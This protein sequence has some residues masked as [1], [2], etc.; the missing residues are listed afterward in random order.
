MSTL[1]LGF[2][3]P[4]QIS[5]AQRG[6]IT[7]PNRKSLA[8]LAYLAVESASAHS[9]ES[10]LSL[11]WPESPTSAA[12]NNLRVTWSILRK[13]LKE[14]SS[15]QEPFLQST[16][17][18]LQFN[19][20]S[21]HWLDVTAFENLLACCNTHNHAE[22]QNCDECATRLAQAAELVRGEFLG[23]FS[24]GD[25]PT[26]DEW[27]LI[28]RERLHLQI[29][30][31]LDDLTNYHD[32]AGNFDQATSYA[33][34]LLEL[35][36]L[37]EEAHRQL[38]RLFSKTGRR[39]AALS[40]FET[41]RRW[42]ANELGVAPSVETTLLAERI[43]ALAPGRPIALRHNLPV[44]TSRFFGRKQEI[45]TLKELLSESSEF[46][47]LTGPG[48]VGKT[49]LALQVASGLVD[50]FSDGVWFV[51]LSGIDDPQVVPSEVSKVLKVQEESERAMA[52][53]LSNGLQ[54]KSVLL[55][56]DNCEHLLEACTQLI[57]SLRASAPGLVVLATSRVPLRLDSERVVRLQPFAI[58]EKGQIL[59]AASALQYEA[60]QLFTS[61]TAKVQLNFTLTDAN[62]MIVA[63]ICRHLDGMPLAIELA[64][65][66][67]RSMPVEAIAQRLDQRFRWLNAQSSGLIP[68]QR[69]LLTMI[70][71]SHDLLDA[72]E[73]ELFCRLSV[74][75]GGWTVAAAE[76]ICAE[77]EFCL[78][79]LTQL[80]DQS[81][82][83]F[84]VGPAKNR[85]RM[86][87]TIRQYARQQLRTSGEE[88]EVLACHAQYY[89]DLVVQAAKNTP[90]QPLQDRLNLIEA[91]HDNLRPA[92]NWTVTHDPDLALKLVAKLGLDLKFWELRGHF[93]EGRRW[94]Q[95]ILDAT[96]DSVSKTRANA[97]L[98]A[99]ALSSAINDFD[100]GLC[101][102]T[103][104]QY[105]FRQI[106]DLP[107][108]VEAQ[109][110]TA[111]LTCLQGE[112]TGPLAMA[113]EAFRIADQIN[114]Q[115][116]LAKG[117][118]VMGA[119]IYDLADYD[120]AIQHLLPS[121]AL[122]RKL[123]K[124]Y[125][126]A[127]T[128]NTLAACLMEKGD[129]VSASEI[130]QE[131]A[132]I[133]RN[134]SYQRGVAL[135]LHNLAD[136]AMHLGDFQRARELNV[137]S[138]QI[139]RELGL[140]RGYAF[141][142]ENFAILADR[143]NQTAR[144]IQLFAAAQALRQAMCAPIDP[145]T[146]EA[147]THLLADLRTK[148]GEVHYELEWSKGHSMTTDQAIELALRDF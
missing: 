137:E 60:V 115:P 62:A 70:D 23:G 66:R 59:N 21:D 41:C 140:R 96:A 19:S 128:L 3:G 124:P 42:L 36:P 33:R 6:N 133:N 95:R 107:G 145:V 136:A 57:K 22:V 121:V 17:L 53:S 20:L 119:I 27:A 12:Q 134:L 142:L 2:L 44:A 52:Q 71:W 72:P 127:R 106:G 122:W 13:S 26:F 49:R 67:A 58:P 113:Q 31:V 97:L 148:V 143:K 91:E 85:Y 130:L 5:H 88:S 76:A 14:V 89:V 129:Y 109:L 87:E 37:R 73:R 43:R 39:S 46:V 38:M 65:T 1:K 112:Q 92:F 93:E 63:Q 11:L 118:Y 69:T 131:T 108:E 94:L 55:V 30:K 28:Q 100:Y 105:I 15:E 147:Y 132:E 51:E 144:S 98:A 56:L 81:L 139:R 48:G 116:G 120:H 29:T 77:G 16:R 4:P 45:D 75:A 64:A 32:V 146:Q 86:H 111:D 102:A 110:E 123:G 78:E 83:D 74:F 9:R 40:Q 103:E 114:D 25:C 50:R 82:I 84:G 126:L 99:A 18:E 79:I 117:G 10:L 104:S 135:A 80:V 7:L 141:S 54:D 125:E 8:L 138:L 101:C 61:Q 68:R 35:D 34:R 24:L 90:E 47:T